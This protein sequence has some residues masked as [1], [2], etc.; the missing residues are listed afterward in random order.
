MLSSIRGYLVLHHASFAWQRGH[1]HGNPS[2]PRGRRILTRHH[3]RYGLIASQI[4]AKREQGWACLTATGLNLIGRVGHKLFTD[5]NSDWAKYADTL[6]E[7]DWPRSAEIWQGNIIKS[8]KVMT[9]QVPLRE[10]YDAVLV[11]IGLAPA[12]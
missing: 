5:G 12:A 7:V 9:Q 6:A 8:N 3:S 4:P 1:I 2:T 10:G 11:K